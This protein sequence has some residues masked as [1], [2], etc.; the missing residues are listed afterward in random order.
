MNDDK[1]EARLR[2]LEAM[3]G[4]DMSMDLFNDGYETL[5]NDVKAMPG[6]KYKKLE[7]MQKLV[8]RQF[9]YLFNEWRRQRAIDTMADKDAETTL[10][11]MN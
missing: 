2:E 7:R 1:F 3:T 5:L 9:L 6:P 8:Y 4:Q 10:E 11:R